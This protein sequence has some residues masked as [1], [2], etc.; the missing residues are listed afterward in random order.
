MSTSDQGFNFRLSAGF[1]TD[2]ADETYVLSTDSYPTTRG[3]WT[4]G[5][6]S[7]AA[8]SRNRDSGID[9]RFAGS[10]FETSGDC[11]F[12]IDLPSSGE[13]NIRMVIG[14]KHAAS[15]PKALFDLLDD[16]TIF[17]SVG[18][19]TLSNNLRKGSDAAG[20]LL[21]DGSTIGSFLAEWIAS[22]SPVVRTFASTVFVFRNKTPSSG[23]SFIN[24]IRLV[25]SVAAPTGVTYHPLS[26][27]STHPLRF[28]I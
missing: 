17:Q 27:R 3:G 11:D 14:D 20:N 4:F 7:G 12:R 24:H 22:N 5:Y 2:A 16:V 21:G 6:S 1:V 15:S 8:V 18:Q 28:S 23:A 26:S 19:L 10:H 13:W 9:R 25:K